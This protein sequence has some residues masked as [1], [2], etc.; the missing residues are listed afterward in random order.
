MWHMRLLHGDAWTI[1][2][3]ETAPDQVNDIFSNDN[4]ALLPDAT[5]C[6][7]RELWLPLSIFILSLLRPH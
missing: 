4:D 3:G 2:S 6:D 5:R 7:F 1:G